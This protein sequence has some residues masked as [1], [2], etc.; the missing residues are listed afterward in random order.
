M[1]TALV[2][3]HKTHLKYKPFRVEKHYFDN[4]GFCY[5]EE[6]YTWL[7]FNTEQEAKNALQELEAAE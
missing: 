6:K 3:S 4:D 2:V 7:E 1:K 5:K